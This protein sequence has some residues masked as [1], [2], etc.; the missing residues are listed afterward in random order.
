MATTNSWRPV[1]ARP[2]RA[3]PPR[4]CQTSSH[5]GVDPLADS[6]LSACRR[7]SLRTDQLVVGHRSHAAAHYR[8]LATLRAVGNPLPPA[9]GFR[10]LPTTCTAQPG[11]QRRRPAHMARHHPVKSAAVKAVTCRCNPLICCTCCLHAMRMVT[12]LHV[13]TNREES[14]NN[15]KELW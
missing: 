7:H 1:D 5:V 8:R 9:A 4:P 2:K 15:K 14:A 3:S 6:K 12:V 10:M 11:T 13:R